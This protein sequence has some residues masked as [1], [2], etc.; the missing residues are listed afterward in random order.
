MNSESLRQKLIASARTHSPSDSVPYAFEQR[1][2]AGLRRPGPVV[3]AWNLWGAALWRAVAP[4]L[5]ITLLVAASSLA[6]GT[7]PDEAAEPFESMLLA[8][9]TT[10]IVEMP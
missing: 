8:D 1:I 2:M 7:P 3:D 10:Q 6:L 9:L 5:G 4:C